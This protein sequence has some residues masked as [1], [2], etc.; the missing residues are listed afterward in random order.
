MRL[1]NRFCL[2]LSNIDYLFKEEETNIFRNK[3]PDVV[4]AINKLP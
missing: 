3:V 2:N 1:L 4:K